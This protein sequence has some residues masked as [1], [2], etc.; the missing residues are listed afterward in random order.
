[1]LGGIL[2]CAYASLNARRAAPD[3]KSRPA[4]ELVILI[5]TPGAGSLPQVVCCV[6]SALGAGRCACRDTITMLERN[7]GVCNALAKHVV[8][9]H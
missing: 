1:M 9:H 2:L 7:N 8:D 5:W 6:D 3:S 4:V